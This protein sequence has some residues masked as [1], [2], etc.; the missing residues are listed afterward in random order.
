[1]CAS[2]AAPGRHENAITGLYRLK[3]PPPQ[4]VA[5]T[6]WPHWL[7]SGMDV[8]EYPILILE[9]PAALA[10]S[11]AMRV[12][13]VLCALC[14]AFPT[15]WAQRPVALTDDHPIVVEHLVRL[16]Y[17]LTSAIATRN[18]ADPQQAT[19]RANGLRRVF[20]LSE[21]GY[22]TMSM[23]LSATK[24]QLDQLEAEQNQYVSQLMQTH[25][26]ASDEKLQGFFNRKNAILRSARVALQSQLSDGDWQGL[27]NF[28]LTDIVGVLKVGKGLTN[29]H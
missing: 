12:A 16:H 20:S 5:F 3:G 23:V 28:I 19:A 6:C 14:A 26:E 17:A 11:A 24:S 18:S 7:I 21:S 13:T 2:S 22:T 1:M 27:R 29:A 25:S 8:L 15:A 4:D 10:H 9:R